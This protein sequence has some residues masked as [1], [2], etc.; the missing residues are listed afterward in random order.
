MLH[1]F[2]PTH[3]THP[4]HLILIYLIT[5]TIYSDDPNQTVAHHTVLPS[6]L[7]IPATLAQISH[8]AHVLSLISKKPSVTLI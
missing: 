3:A 5:Q 6:T 1:N 2:S 8:L 7:L 4:T